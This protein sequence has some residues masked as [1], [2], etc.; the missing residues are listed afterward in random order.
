[1]RKRNTP[2]ASIF[3]SDESPQV[4]NI[5]DRWAFNPATEMSDAEKRDWVRVHGGNLRPETRRY[6]EHLIEGKSCE[7]E[8]STAEAF[9]EIKRLIIKG[10]FLCPI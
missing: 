7:S 6:I 8:V 9:A 1:M 4:V 2:I 10:E 3:G 5:A